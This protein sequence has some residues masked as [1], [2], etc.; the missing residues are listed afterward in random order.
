MDKSLATGAGE[1]TS[2]KVVRHTVAYAVAEL[3]LLRRA[4]G[5]DAPFFGITQPGA[6]G[7]LTAW[8]ATL[9]SRTAGIRAKACTAVSWEGA[10]QVCALLT[11]FESQELPPL[12][13]L[14]ETGGLALVG[15]I[16]GGVSLHGVDDTRCVE[17]KRIGLSQG[18]SAVFVPCAGLL[19]ATQGTRTR[20]S[21]LCRAS[22]FLALMQ[23]PWHRRTGGSR[24]SMTSGL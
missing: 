8:T 17:L 6:P 2:Y 24:C 22:V 13:A 12:T 15:D 1:G 16:A 9:P 5:P 10:G 11:F 21:P 18:S 19:I 14:A 4:P 20:T 3:A 7:R 23:L